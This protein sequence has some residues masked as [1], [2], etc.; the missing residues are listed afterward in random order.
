MVSF[1]V[2]VEG[3]LRAA[4]FGHL[5]GMCCETR[6]WDMGLGLVIY[7]YHPHVRQ[8]GVSILCRVVEWMLTRPSLSASGWLVTYPV[9]SPPDTQPETA[10]GD[11]QLHP[12]GG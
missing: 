9:R 7:R 10:G 4:G 5:S 2:V 11:Q 3:L 12:E 1:R 8:Q 6:V